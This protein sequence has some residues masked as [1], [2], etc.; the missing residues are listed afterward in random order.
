MVTDASASQNPAYRSTPRHASQ[1]TDD[2]AVSNLPAVTAPVD[3]GPDQ[4][5]FAGSRG[6]ATAVGV[7]AALGLIARI[8]VLRSD[9]GDLLADEAFTGLLSRDI[10][11]G[12]V[13]VV[14]ATIRYTAPVESYLFAPFVALFGMNTLAL[15]LLPVVFWALASIVLAL[16]ARSAGLAGRW[17]IAGAL[18]WMAPGALTVIA[19][20]SYEGYASGLSMMALMVLFAIRSVQDGGRRDR[21]L[22]G[23]TAGAAIWFHPMFIP[24]VVPVLA[25]LA[26]RFRRELKG[27]WIPTAVA[28]IIGMSPFLLWNIV[29][30]WP[31]LTQPAAASESAISRFAHL[32][33]DLFPRLIGMEGYGN[34]S[35]FPAW[36]TI[37]V[38][39][40]AIA[41]VARG[42]V[43]LSQRSRH[44]GMLI[45]A[46][47]VV[48][49]P[50]MAL[51]TNM[52]FVDDGR[53][54]MIFLPFVVIAVT[55]GI[56]T[57]PRA[58]TVTSLAA[59]IL[60]F[61]VLILPWLIVHLDRPTTRLNDGPL[62]VMEELDERG[63]TRL[64]GYFWTVLPV[65]FLSDQRIRVA[66][67]GHPGVIM[68]PNTQR[69]VEQSPAEDVALVFTSEP[70]EPLLRLPRDR[71]ETIEIDDLILLIPR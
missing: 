71:Y 35:T 70:P 22:T 27:W 67:A 32:L 2:A 62:K 40:A 44:L 8:W 39:I 48:G 12:Y 9:R 66:V 63:I 42:I 54:S 14:M 18:A 34:R 20:R 5:R 15:K 45:G 38:S 56:P 1:P 3:T 21:W 10:L 25:V 24:V 29:N 37:I 17:P 68:L 41:V 36:L 58:S 47:L 50:L 46:P 19:V 16:A 13:P 26:M 65:E 4:R 7:A 43:I 53:Y 59:P 23:L 30:N 6:V 11:D 52:S 55:A 33:T 69:L 57:P 49:W 64:A 28:G 61:G 60:W 51:F 31:S